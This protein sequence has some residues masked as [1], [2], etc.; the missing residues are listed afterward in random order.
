MTIVILEDA[1][2]DLEAGRRF[3]E[4]RQ[5]GIGDYFV[6]SIL[7]DLES[8]VLYAGIHRKHFGFYR[9]L[10]RRFPFGIYYEFQHETVFIYAILDLRRKPSRIT[11]TLKRRRK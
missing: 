8:L 7:S 11:S 3:Y 1:A 10:S 2:Q 9:V 5:S 4:S 6:E